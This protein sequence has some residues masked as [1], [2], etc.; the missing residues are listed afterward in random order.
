MA[1]I[2]FSNVCK[3]YNGAQAVKDL[4]FQVHEGETIVLLGT[5]GCGKTTTL[6]MINR[7]LEPTEGIIKI[8]HKDIEDYNPIEL[9][10]SIGYVIQSIGLF[11]HFTIGRN[12][13]AVLE[14]LNTPKGKI[15]KRV[16]ELCGMVGLNPQTY[17]N[18][19]TAELSGGQQQRVGVARA[20]AA[21]PPV[22]L[23]D[24]PFGALDPI[25]REELQNEFLA[26][27][28][29]IKKTI[30]F[31]THDMFE[32]TKIADRIALMDKGRL[33]QIDKPEN[34]VKNP[35]NKFV[36]DFLGK[37][38]FQLAMLLIKTKDLMEEPKQI[39]FQ[40]KHPIC[41]PEESTVLD[42]INY[43]K[44]SSVQIVP[45]KNGKGE[46]IGQVSREDVYKKVNE[47]I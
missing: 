30:I 36:A 11:P 37:H 21:D 20:L 10:R 25:T 22:L 12:I 39:D 16:D 47:N 8:G 3:N 28:Q 42:T 2:K 29:R 19:Y 41:L 31:V 33:I 43:L 32:A 24:E 44:Q 5:S 7:L 15:S 6:K 26:L 9:R 13:G 18:R 23:M 27:E 38:R 45:V 4:S 34:I 14:L 1:K 17:K 40:K 46:I 35:A